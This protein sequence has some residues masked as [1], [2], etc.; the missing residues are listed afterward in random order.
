MVDLEGIVMADALRTCRTVS[1]FERYLEANLGP[2]LGSWAN[3]GVIDAS[4]KAWL[5]EVHNHGFEKHD[6]VAAPSGYLVNTNFARSGKP[7]EGMGYLRC[8]RASELLAET[9][10]LLTTRHTPAE[11]ATHQNV[12]AERALET[13]AG[14]R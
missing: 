11:F 8:E 5:F 9:A 12:L 6:A 14:I 10:D 1:D 4:G 2:Q 13:L 7:G 3:F